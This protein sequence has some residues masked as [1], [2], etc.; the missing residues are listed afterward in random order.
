MSSFGRRFL[1]FLSFFGA[2]SMMATISFSSSSS[3]NVPGTSEDLRRLL[4]KSL[5]GATTGS[6]ALLLL[7]VRSS[8]RGG[9][10]SFLLTG[11]SS[12]GSSY[13]D[14]S[15]ACSKSAAGSSLAT[16][17]S[18]AATLSGFSTASSSSSESDVGGGDDGWAGSATSS[19]VSW[20]AL[21]PLA[22]LLLRDLGCSEDFSDASSID[23]ASVSSKGM[24]RLVIF[25]Q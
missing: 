25:L 6:S 11:D 13:C 23:L 24:I 9:G 18:S 3:G 1:V 7:L 10:G 12:W 17:S 14:T 19:G 22:I 8:W 16:G 2:S 21:R 5:S 15:P 4:G 20:K